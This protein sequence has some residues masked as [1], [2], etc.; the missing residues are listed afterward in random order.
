MKTLLVPVDLSRVSNRVCIVA[1]DL[2]RAAGA[3]L[4][5][6]HVVPPQSIALRAYGFAAAEVRTM[7]AGLEKR[8][9]RRLLALAR[10]CEQRGV[11]VQA[12][13]RTGV[14]AATVLAKAASLR[15]AMIVLGSHG[16]SA[17]FDLV[18]GS[19]AQ[20]ILRKSSVPVV[21]VPM[22]PEKT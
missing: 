16:H 13:L 8:E 6:L 17:A 2:A 9:M 19:T 1:C 12:I 5:L 7:M 4:V 11:K 3:K 14:P 20:K 18:V 22:R 10:R 15:A 21:V